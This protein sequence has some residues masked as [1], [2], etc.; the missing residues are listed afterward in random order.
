MK[1]KNRN[2]IDKSKLLT[3]NLEGFI[4]EQK[5]KLLKEIDNLNLM[6]ADEESELK[7][8]VDNVKTDVL[9]SYNNLRDSLIK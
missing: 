8:N 9:K 2:S 1:K 6:V 5:D 4:E 7:N 3:S